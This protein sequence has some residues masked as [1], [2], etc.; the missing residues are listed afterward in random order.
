MADYRNILY[1]KQRKGVLISDVNENGPSYAAGM[2]RGD[3]VVAFNGKEVQSVS[4]LRNLVARTTVGKEADIKI[5]R[6][7]KEQS[8]KIKVAERPSD[9]VL[10]KRE[11]AP[12]APSETIKPPDNVLAALR[13]Q[14]LD[15][16]M[17]SQ[18]NLPTKTTGVVVSSVESGSP[19]ESAGLQRGDVIQEI[20]HEVVKTLEDYQKASAK[21]KK[22]EMV[23]LLLSRQGNNLF[24]A[25]NP[26]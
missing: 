24:V 17:M 7:G 23:V 21:V 9:E 3:V 19:A 20:N 25:V 22:D 1:E 10:A 2:K 15:A 8:L 4:Q 11:P 12:S 26:K 5:L 13:V 16:A 18:L 14:T 6:E